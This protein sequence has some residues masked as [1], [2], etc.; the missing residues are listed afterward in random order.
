MNDY[1]ENMTFNEK[2][3]IFSF[4]YLK[5][6]V[7]LNDFDDDEYIFTKKLYSKLV[8]TSKIL[9]DFLDFHGAKKNREW[10]YYR[11]LA[12]TI[13]HL[14]L[15]CYSQRHILNRLMFYSL[16]EHQKKKFKKEA[17]NTLKILQNAIKKAGSSALQEAKRLNINVPQK[18]Y[19]ISF[20][21][22]ISSTQQLDHNI[23]DFNARDRQSE[24]LTR[25]ASEFLEV[26][27]EFDQFAFYERYDLKKIHEL[28]PE[29]I[30]EVTI[31]R[32]EM[33]V[34]NIQSSF[35]SYV[36][37]AESSSQ[38]AQLDQL[39]SHFSIVFHI[40]QVLGR[41]LHFYERH[42]YD[43]GYKDV[44]K[45]VRTSLASLIDPDVLLDSA[46]NF[47]LFYAWKFLSSGKALASRIL[48]ENMETSLIEVT[49]PKDRGFHS[50]PSLLV[51]KIVQ[52]YGGEVQMIVNGD[53]FDAA[54]VLDIQW[55]GGKINKEDIESVKFKG[56]IRALNDLKILAGV[57]YGEDHMGKG[58]PLPKE[59]SYLI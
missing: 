22:G 36:V 56:D 14:A 10:V 41:L 23:D 7:F 4:E 16:E 21:P 9:E 35:D 29:K 54:S 34:H 19:Q 15:A 32:Y 2:S 37:N 12:A 43:T 51:A 8:T 26:V 39:R 55:A 30:N 33:V 27:K 25:I 49:I 13:Q 42:L 52:H 59:L 46:V 20:F 58:I 24:N 40:L 38:H 6:I 17:F 28:V 3:N 31:R 1:N 5:C 11:E 47:C 48:N 44:Y 53:V 45:N 50:R 18:G 57:N